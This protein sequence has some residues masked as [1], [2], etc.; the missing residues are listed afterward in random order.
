MAGYSTPSPMALLLL[1]LFAVGGQ[2]QLSQSLCSNQNTGASN[3]PNYSIYQSNGLC[4]DTCKDQYAFAVVQYQNCWCSNF[5]PAD[6]VDNSECSQAC[7]GYPSELCGNQDSGLFGYIAL[8]RQ[9]SGTAGS[10]PTQTSQ[11]RTQQTRTSRP[12][13]GLSTPTEDPSTSA[14]PSTTEASPSPSTTDSPPPSPITSSTS[15]ASPPPSTSFSSP[16]PPSTVTSVITLT[17]S[18]SSTASSTESSTESSEAPVTSTQ[19]VTVSG[20]IV[21]QTVT[22]TPRA[23]TSGTAADNLTERPAQS[24]SPSGGV[25]AGAVVGSL[26][27][28]AFIL[29]ALFFLWRRRRQEDDRRSSGSSRINRNASVLSKAG[30]LATGRNNTT[31]DPEK[32]MEE[33]RYG[34]QRQSA[35]YDPPE[36]PVSAPGGVYDASSH[37]SRRNSRPLVYD[38]RL[39]PAAIMQDWEGNGSR[40]SIGTMQDQ[41]DYSRPL[42]IA[43]PDVERD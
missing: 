11:T 22:S 23:R 2:A 16:P 26:A 6:T 21:T 32:S 5:A 3:Q 12:T 33:P 43:N 8:Q 13:T 34:S 35:L 25:I 10:S 1:T 9:P 27:G 7:P 39:N 4:Y 30:L 38:Q 37:A 18:P 19:V 31:A 14:A 36:S 41:R 42:G 24:N 40:T 20:A 29:L 17:S 28:L 15:T